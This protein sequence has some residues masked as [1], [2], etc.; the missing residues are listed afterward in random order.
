MAL[1]ADGRRILV[2]V[3]RRALVQAGIGLL[4]GIPIAL[5]ASRAIASQLFEV[6]ARDPMV[7]GVALAVL[8]L[9]TAV[10][11]AVPARRAARVDP[12]RALRAQ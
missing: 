3:V 5:L 10:A 4:V 12:T 6:D 7:L 8:L 9:T 1:G 2:D 11:A